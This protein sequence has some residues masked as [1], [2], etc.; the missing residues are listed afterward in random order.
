MRPDNFFFFCGRHDIF[1]IFNNNCNSS[2]RETPNEHNQTSFMCKL[3]ILCLNIFIRVRRIEREWKR[4]RERERERKR[5]RKE[6]KERVKKSEREKSRCCEKKR[7]RE[8]HIPR[9]WRK[10]IELPSP[11]ATF[12]FRKSPFPFAKS[13]EKEK[14]KRRTQRHVRCNRE[15]PRSKLVPRAIFQIGY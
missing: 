11:F 12:F 9:K 13:D 7:E 3:W 10:L 15:T 14:K 2:K 6:E 5:E 4:T 8:R 1:P